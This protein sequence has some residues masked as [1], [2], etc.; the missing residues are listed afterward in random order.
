MF[1][2]RERYDVVVASLYQMPVDPFEQFAGH[3]PLDYWGRNLIDH[4]LRL[5]PRLLTENGTAYVMQLSILSQLQTAELLEEAGLAGRVVDFGFFPLTP[6]FERNREQ[7]E[8]VERLSDA[9]HLSFGSEEIMVAYLLEIA[10][11]RAEALNSG[12]EAS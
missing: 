9:F 11:E 1:E 5:L 10:H 4:L 7:I 6:V 8:R 3:R 12:A 2:P